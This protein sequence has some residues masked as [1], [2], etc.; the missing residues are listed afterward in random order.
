MNLSSVTI[1]IMLSHDKQI[2]PQPL[3]VETSC[4]HYRRK[5]LKGD[6]ADFTITMSHHY[7]ESVICSCIISYMA[8]SNKF[9]SSIYGI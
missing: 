4:H 5:D 7:Y 9:L 2:A 8:S 1:Q 3:K 6:S